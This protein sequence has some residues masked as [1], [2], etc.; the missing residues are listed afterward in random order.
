MFIT[1]KLKK[2]ACILVASILLFL[3]SFTFASNT[4]EQPSVNVPI[5]MYHSILKDNSVSPKYIVTPDQLENDLKYIKSHGYETITMT[6]L[7]LYVYEKTPL[8]KKPIILTFD[9]GYYNN[10]FYAYP[11]MEK[12]NAKMVIS[13]VGE[14]TDTFSLSDDSNPNYSH[15]TWNQINDLVKSDC[16]EIQN[17]TYNLHSISDK[18]YGCKKMSYE[19]DEEYQKV[20]KND[21]KSLQDKMYE[22][23]G[24]MP[25]TFTYPYGG[26]SKASLGT[27]K[28]LGFK[29]SLS[30]NEGINEITKNPECLFELKRVIRPSGLTSE[31][32]FKNK[33]EK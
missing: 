4:Q 26:I 17:H 14:F 6:D 23:T 12:Y 28:E 11:L 20:L 5:I 27:V 19:S 10:L 1:V 31:D 3:I 24:Y 22:K 29:A 16:A 9:D 21:L 2:T 18:R 33:I 15:L 32:Y 7:I 8:P 30:C 13:V 25:N